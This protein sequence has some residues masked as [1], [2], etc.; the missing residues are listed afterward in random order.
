MQVSWEQDGV[1]VL[2]QELVR[3]SWEQDGVLV[4]ELVRVSWE[5]DGVLVL[6]QELVQVSWEQ[7]EEQGRAL[8]QV[9]WELAKEGCHLCEGQFQV[10]A[11]GLAQELEQV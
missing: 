1:L 7:D 3:V 4:Q 6:V 5:Q 9:L 8:G 11:L 2:V 10:Q